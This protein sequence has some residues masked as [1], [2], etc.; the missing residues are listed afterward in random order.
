MIS[1]EAG[2]YGPASFVFGTLSDIEGDW[3]TWD[4]ILRRDVLIF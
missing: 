3:K 2:L 1:F 4:F